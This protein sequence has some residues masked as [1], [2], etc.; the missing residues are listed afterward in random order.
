[1]VLLM[2]TVQTNRETVSQSQNCISQNLGASFGSA[3][4]VI[5]LP[6][7]LQSVLGSDRQYWSEWMKAMLTAAEFSN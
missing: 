7:S 5:G 4:S 3:L 1:M 6:S 2:I